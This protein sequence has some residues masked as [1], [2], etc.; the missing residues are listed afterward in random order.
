MLLESMLWENQTEEITE[1]FDRYCDGSVET[2]N[3]VVTMQNG[4]VCN[5]CGMF[6][7]YQMQNEIY[8]RVIKLNS[9]L[10]HLQATLL[11]LQAMSSINSRL[12]KTKYH[13]QFIEDLEHRCGTNL[14]LLN[15][16]KN[17]KNEDQKYS[18]YFYRILALKQLIIKDR[19]LEFIKR[20]YLVVRKY[21]RGNK[22]RCYIAQFLTILCDKYPHLDYIKEYIIN[23]FKI[24]EQLS[25]QFW[26][27]L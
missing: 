20:K 5:K 15:I 24:K 7:R 22:T 11:R 3:I 23:K 1:D 19:D 18:N 14:S 16:H 4:L 6:L 9:P 2:H 8:P 27:L 12:I 10:K 13:R 17:L 25:R 26:D 21:C